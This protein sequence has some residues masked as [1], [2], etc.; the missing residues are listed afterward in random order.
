MTQLN[1]YCNYLED[2]RCPE[3]SS[4]R[5]TYNFVV[6]F[7]KPSREYGIGEDEVEY[8]VVTCVNWYR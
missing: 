5:G 6:V 4:H 1:R 8:N 2:K 7:E 3:G